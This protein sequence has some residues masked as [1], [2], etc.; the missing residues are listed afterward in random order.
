MVSKIIFSH[1]YASIVCLSSY[2]D[3]AKSTCYRIQAIIIL[4]PGSYLCRHIIERAHSLFMSI[5]ISDIY[6]IYN[7]CS[8]SSFGV[9]FSPYTLEAP[10]NL[11]IIVY[12]GYPGILM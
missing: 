9:P 3:P 4:R 7:I 1:H 11:K 5:E 8:R 2:S 10:L 12:L 6:G